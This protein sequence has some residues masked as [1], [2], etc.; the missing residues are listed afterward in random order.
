A[1]DKLINDF[2]RNA[3]QR[4]RL[5]LL[6][7][8]AWHTCSFST[9]YASHTKFLTGSHFPTHSIHWVSIHVARIAQPFGVGTVSGDQ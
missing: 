6:A 5:F 3:R 7:R 8:L 2:F 4:R 9:W 1:A